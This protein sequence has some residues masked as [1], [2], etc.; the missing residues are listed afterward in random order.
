MD[1]RSYTGVAESNICRF[2]HLRQIRI[3]LRWRRSFWS[4]VDCL[5]GWR[6]LGSR[7]VPRCTILL[8]TINE[9]LEKPSPF[10]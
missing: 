10:C 8:I 5:S 4:I 9:T 3:L 1:A 7:V 2:T 6:P